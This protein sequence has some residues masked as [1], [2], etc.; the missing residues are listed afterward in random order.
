MIRRLRV[1]VIGAYS[2]PNPNHNTYRA[3]K[4][5]DLLCSLGYAPLIPHLSHFWDTMIPHEYPFWLQLDLDLAHGC[6]V[7]LWDKDYMPGESS[8]GD[9]EVTQGEQWGKPVFRS[10]AALQAKYP[11]GLVND[12]SEV[13]IES[14]PPP[15]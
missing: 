9:K 4:F 1:Y 14:V 11:G 8:G 12:T 5:G 3:I 7:F 6:D 10:L 13:R 15:T 2:R